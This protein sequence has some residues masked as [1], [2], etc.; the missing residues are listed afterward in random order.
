MLLLL[1][2]SVL[3]GCHRNDRV[4]VSG[5]VAIDGQAADYGLVSFRPVEGNSGAGSG[6]SL[7][8]GKFEIPAQQ[9]LLPGKYKVAVQAFRKTG[10]T[11]HDAEG[12]EFPDWIAVPIDPAGLPEAT[13]VVGGVPNRF[14]FQLT[15]AKPQE[16][17]P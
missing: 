16:M 5:T 12:S 2:A 14:E 1:A 4:P 13:V 8:A 17:T 7:R 6:A 15:T 11:L 10:R 9:G 3:A